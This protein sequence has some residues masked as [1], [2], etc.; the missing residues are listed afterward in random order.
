MLFTVR[1]LQVILCFCDAAGIAK[2]RSVNGLL[3]APLQH[4]LEVR[5]VYDNRI[6]E[7][8]TGHP[9]FLRAALSI[10]IDYRRCGDV[11]TIRYAY[12]SFGVKKVV[13]HLD[14]SV[15]LRT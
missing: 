5:V 9:L 6:I 12:Q 4:L 8:R 2:R 7:G 13:T 14:R 1:C 15:M 11:G 10:K 3:L